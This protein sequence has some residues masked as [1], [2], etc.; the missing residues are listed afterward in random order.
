M[1]LT[2]GEEMMVGLMKKAGLTDDE[3][4]GIMLMLRSK[5]ER[6]E[7]LLW[8]Y[9]HKKSMTSQKLLR[10]AMDIKTKKS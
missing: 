7:L 5:E 10:K 8:M 9:Q 2:N 3:T 4:V 1:A 6:K